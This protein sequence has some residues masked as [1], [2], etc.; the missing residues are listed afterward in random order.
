M[1]VSAS[2]GMRL[3]VSAIITTDLPATEV[4]AEGNN[5]QADRRPNEHAD[6]KH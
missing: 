4:N 6:G 1:K 2:P 5:K 3:N